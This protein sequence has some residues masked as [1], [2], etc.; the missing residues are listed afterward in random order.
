MEKNLI[1]TSKRLKQARLTY[2]VEEE[3]RPIKGYE[4][5]YSVSNYGRVK[6]IS[7]L[8]N[9]KL[10][11]GKDAERRTKE[12]I[13]SMQKTN[14]GYLI[15]HLHLNN[16]RKAKTVHRLVALA[17]CFRA[18]P[19]YEVNHINGDKTDNSFYNLEWVS[20]KRNHVHAVEIGLN[21][22]AIK[23]INPNTG[24]YFPSISQAAKQ[25]HKAHRTVRKDFMKA[26]NA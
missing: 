11:N 17:F 10:R 12:R 8:Q 3:W 18:H 13:L 24:E 14:A 2:C 6:S 9:Y 25:T 22:Q 1:H 19:A 15:V 16:E 26:K 20:R 7:F 4:H 5:R 21:T 23:V